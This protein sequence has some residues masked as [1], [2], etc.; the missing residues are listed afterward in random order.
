[1]VGV[2]LLDQFHSERVFENWLNLIINRNITSVKAAVKK[3]K[4]EKLVLHFS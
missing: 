2:N 4:G 3:N 1:M